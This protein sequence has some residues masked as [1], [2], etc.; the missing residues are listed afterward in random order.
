M[1]E[2]LLLGCKDLAAARSRLR[3]GMKVTRLNL[4]L[5]LHAKAGIENLWIRLKRDGNRNQKMASTKKGAGGNRAER[6]GEAGG[7]AREAGWGRWRS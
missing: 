4:N 6:S 1:A 7:R 2:H 3:D 5:L